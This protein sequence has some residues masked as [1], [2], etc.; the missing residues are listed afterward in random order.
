MRTS[1]LLPLAWASAVSA[2]PILEK[3]QGPF[4]FSPIEKPLRVVETE[5][6]IKPGSKH[7]N[8]IYGPFEIP[9]GSQTKDAMA[10]G[11]G[12]GKASNPLESLFS[13]DG[14]ANLLQPGGIEKMMQSMPGFSMDPGGH[15][16]T[17][18]VNEG[19]C[20]GEDSARQA[21]SSNN[22]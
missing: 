15:T 5:G 4:F 17:R 14:L 9:A 12:H 20:K 2:N 10:S 7:V 13:G 19:I 3:R 1:Q 8:V 6:S 16:I 22:V 21:N 11:H 18:R